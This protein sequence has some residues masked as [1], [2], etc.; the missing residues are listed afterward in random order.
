MCS[1]LWI[2]HFGVRNQSKK[3]TKAYNASSCRITNTSI[4]AIE[5]ILFSFI[6]CS[7]QILCPCKEIVPNYTWTSFD[8]LCTPVLQST[9]WMRGMFAELIFFIIFWTFFYV[10]FLFTCTTILSLEELR[11]NY[12]SCRI[13]EK[14]LANVCRQII[15]LTK[16]II[17]TK[18]SHFFVNSPTM[19]TMDKP[20]SSF[21]WEGFCLQT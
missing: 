16:F 18:C 5:G 9:L 14:W 1:I 2:H 19:L 8:V 4:W 13:E 10:M 3:Q 6:W 20:S 7:V 21:E 15:D 11:G 17:K 12:G